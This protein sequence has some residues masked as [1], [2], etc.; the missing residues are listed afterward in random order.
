MNNFLKKIIEKK[1]E[2][3][4]V[5]KQNR[6]L[7]LFRDKMVIIA[8]IK[9]ASPTVP[10][11]GSEKDIIK[12]AVN[13]EAGG[14]NAISVIT[15]KH[16]FKGNIN[17]ISKIKNEINLP[18]LQKDFVIDP[19]QIYEAKII[20]ADA[21]LLIAK[22]LDKKTL[23]KFVALCQEIGLEPIV[24][25]NDEKDLEKAIVSSTKII[26]VN[27]RSLKTFV[28]DVDKACQLMKRI[29]NRLIKLGF[30]GIKSSEEVKKYQQA[31]AKGVLI[32]TA[33]MKAKNVKS[34]IVSFPR[35]RKSSQVKVCGIRTLESAQTAV[36]AGADFLGFNFVPTSKRYIKP[37]VAKKIISQ[38][39]SNV[40]IVGVFQNAK[41]DYIN[42]I[43]KLLDLDFVQLHEKRIIKSTKDKTT[44][45]LV[46]RKTQGVGKL[47]NLKESKALA[48]SSEIFFAGG[49]NL[50]N[51]EEVIK[52]VHPFAVDVAGGIE[53][54]G[55]Q[56]NKKIKKFITIVKGVAL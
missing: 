21:L 46:D 3:I 33:L 38:I 49:L 7:S 41:T 15:E 31:G 37:E 17:F 24:E 47:P 2:D 25:I 12:R 54:N 6:F 53:T 28:V 45:L 13:Y 20:G 22:I 43:A 8:E 19:Y 40:K 18:I 39:K 1:Q 36:D 9:L 5:L 11:F 55:L 30:S 52:K 56:D 50:D 10:Y 51:V 48:K 42:K 14:A 4:A 16:F 35:R 44:Y 32:G 29:P 27:A 26:A 34:F 23:I